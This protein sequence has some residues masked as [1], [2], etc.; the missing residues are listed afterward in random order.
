MLA[1]FL[2]S[3]V[4]KGGGGR[5]RIK[6]REPE[7]LQ[8]PHPGLGRTN[9]RACSCVDREAMGRFCLPGQ[10][11]FGAA[12]RCVVERADLTLVLLA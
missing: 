2:A 3:E 1:G 5:D 11:L 10:G 12:L 6:D 9:Q 7:T 4:A 8:H